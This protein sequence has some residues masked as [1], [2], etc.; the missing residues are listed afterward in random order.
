[1][2]DGWCVFLDDYRIEKSATVFLAFL[3]RILIFFLI[4]FLFFWFLLSLF[5]CMCGCMMLVIWGGSDAR[6]WAVQIVLSHLSR[7]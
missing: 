1:M 5:A 7:D 4:F 6:L 2:D 3:L